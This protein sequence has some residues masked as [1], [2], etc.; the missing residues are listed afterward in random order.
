MLRQNNQNI[1]K[2]VQDI[3]TKADELYKKVSLD[4]V[5]KDA[6]KLYI[7][8]NAKT[9]LLKQVIK[10]K[11]RIISSSDLDQFKQ[12]IDTLYQELADKVNRCATCAQQIDNS[13]SR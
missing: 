7:A 9:D 8:I 12:E 3:E 13:I 1:E 2:Y 4:S 11:T 10:S 6:Q 5:K